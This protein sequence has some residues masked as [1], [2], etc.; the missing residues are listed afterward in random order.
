MRTLPAVRRYLGF[1]SLSVLAACNALPEAGE[2]AAP[3]SD[4]QPLAVPTNFL[5]RQG[6]QLYLNGAPYQMVGVNAF[7]LTGCGAVPTDA[8][9]DAF[10]AGLRPN[11]L[12]RTWA[13]RPQGLARIEK[14]V[15]AAEKYNQKLI[16]TL[17]DGRSYCGEW[18]GYN[19]SDGSGKQPSWYS[20]GYRTNYVPWVREVVTRF[21]DSASVGMWE[22]LNEPGDA[23]TATI[24]AFF[25]DV[26]TTIKQLDPNHLISS[27]A[28]APWAYGGEAGFQSL[29]DVPNIDVG[30]LHEYDY[31]YNNGNT[32][33][34]PHFGPSIRAM[35][36]LNKPLIIG[37]TGIN[38]ADSNCRTNRTTRRDAMRQKF[39]QYLGGGAAAVFVW[40]WGPNATTACE[41]TFGPNDPLIPMIRDFP[42]AEVPPPPPPGDTVQ[43][44]DATLGSGVG[45][46]QYVGTWEA[47]TGTGKFQQDDHYSST[48][49]ASYGVLFEGTQVKLYGS[50]ASHHG[51]ASVSVDNGTPVDVDFYASARQDQKLL[52][53]SPVLSAG[54]H[55][56][57]VTV[58]GRKN[59]A[60]S[61]FVI[62]ADRVD[63]TRPQ[64]GDTTAPTVSITQPTGGSVPVGAVTVSVTASDASGVARAELWVDGVKLAEDP[65]SPYS[66]TWN[67]TAGQHSLVAKALDTAGN[68][69]TSAT[70]N[71]SVVG[72]QLVDVQVNDAVVGTGLEQFLYSG[73]WQTGTG[74]AK[75]QQDDHYT[76]TT[77]A[78]YTVRF[79]GTQA[80]LYGSAASHHGIASVS[81]DNG[82]PVD[83]DFYASTRQDQKLLWTSPV[84]SAG[85]HTLT[86]TVSGRKNAA[87][88]GIIIN[89][90]RVDLTV[91][92]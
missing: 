14:V 4:S 35:N 45:Q 54:T 80:R 53:T 19:G 56:L 48:A 75:Y 23:D 89:A 17:A 61:G 74:T 21:R 92:R 15:R 69:G 88:S 52:W 87:S 65:T 50:A 27:G 91:L 77:G 34:S 38:A 72:Q 66:F 28:W 42:L 47:G 85:T 33:V 12:T 1:L 40:N 5:Y 51:I 41:L 8:Q 29:H 84:L 25:N 86:V 36:A 49:N 55:T 11:S 83:V 3:A 79:N 62:N 46:F 82:T 39:Q 24:K 59:A 90:D 6:K 26:S 71:L 10:F 31:D 70:V 9:L 2:D 13:F 73:T 37:E 18:D 7:S 44:N 76:S 60:S 58:S 81:I 20:S 22:L 67:A 64:G 68:L 78:S 30:S 43:L 63:V 16:L 32:I 57:K